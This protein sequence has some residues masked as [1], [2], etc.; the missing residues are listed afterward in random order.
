[1]IMRQQF[2]FHSG[3]SW[4]LIVIAPLSGSA[5]AQPDASAEIQSIWKPQEI[6]YGYTGHT[7]YYQCD[8]YE[9]KVKSILLALGAHPETK[10]RAN[11]CPG[12][13]PT[14]NF[15]VTITTATP[16]PT[17][18][19]AAPARDER[20]REIIQQLDGAKG[21]DSA[22]FPAAWKTVDLSEDRRLNLRPGDCEL[23]E[24]LRNHVLPKLSVKIVEDRLLCTPNQLGI[25]TPRLQVSALVPLRRADDELKSGA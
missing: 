11:G 4:A 24:G 10:V 21:V 9:T 17:P 6:R 3:L 23:M 5:A 18:S 12:N 2:R 1:M 16:A 25:D 22:P 13:R 20:E 15:F 19:G 8:A 7:T 14:R